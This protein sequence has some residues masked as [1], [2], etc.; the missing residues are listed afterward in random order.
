MASSGAQ[1]FR[2]LG[3]QSRANAGFLDHLTVRGN[4]VLAR[5]YGRPCAHETLTCG[6]RGELYVR[7]TGLGW[8]KTMEPIVE[9][10]SA[11]AP[12]GRALPMTERPD[13]GCNIAVAGMTNKIRGAQTCPHI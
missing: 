5:K 8:A 6:A 9:I 10:A 7:E 2:A 12:G 3:E 13:L 4:L 11:L 1:A